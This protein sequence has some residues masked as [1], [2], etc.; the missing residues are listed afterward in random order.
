MSAAVR[1]GKYLRTDLVV[2]IYMATRYTYST[3]ANFGQL[4]RAPARLRR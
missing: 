4:G 3:E 2:E 1:R